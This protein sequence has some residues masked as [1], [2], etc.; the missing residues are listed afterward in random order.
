MNLVVIIRRRP[1]FRQQSRVTTGRA[2]LFVDDTQIG[3]V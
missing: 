2:H 3:L 1:S